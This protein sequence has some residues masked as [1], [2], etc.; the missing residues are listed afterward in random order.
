MDF[1]RI[2]QVEVT[3]SCQAGCIFCPR[4]VLKAEWLSKH[5]DWEH[6]VPILKVLKGGTLVHLQGWGEPLL[7]PRLWAMAAAVRAHKGRVS[8]TT[9]AMLLD[10][11]ASHEI[12]RI[13]LE[14]LAVSMADSDNVGHA[15]LRKGTD[16]DRISANIEYL[17]GLKNHPRLHIAIQMTKPNI[18][19]LPGIVQ[20]AARLGV[21]RVIASNLDCVVGAQVEALKAFGDSVDQISIESVEEAKRR[22]R[23]LKVEVEVF[24]LRVQH[25]L[26]VCSADPL[27]TTVITAAGEIAPCTYLSMP[28]PGDIPRIFQGRMETIP[29]YVFGHVSD[30]IERTLK[31]DRASSFLD[32]YRRRRLASSL[33]NAGSLAL[34]TMPGLRSARWGLLRADLQ[35]AQSTG[36]EELPPAP[37][38]C[39]YCYKL[40]GV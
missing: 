1:K 35:P 30:G 11:A 23:E 13:G 31:G 29:R 32:M 25:Q 17:C 14:F 21:S 34:Q 10:Q 38:Q 16:L 6:F 20:L 28:L 18:G 8:L 12:A 40:F 4:T 3:T 2:I 27:R 26:P 37:D 19:H 39:W 15:D 9:N 24:P 7:H 5:L 22:G 36:Q 33:K